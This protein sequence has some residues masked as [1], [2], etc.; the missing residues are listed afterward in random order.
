MGPFYSLQRQSNQNKMESKFL[1]Q[2]SIL[3]TN[4]MVGS[5]PT[6]RQLKIAIILI[7]LQSS[8]W[9]KLCPQKGYES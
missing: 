4:I 2:N 1:M 7:P 6:S 9:W 5:I 8:K 3:G